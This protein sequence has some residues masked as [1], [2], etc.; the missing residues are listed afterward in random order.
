MILLLH[1]L[2]LFITT[3][4]YY[5]GRVAPYHR[6]CGHRCRPC[7]PPLLSPFLLPSSL[8]LSLLSPPSSLFSSLSSSP[9]SK[10]SS[11]L[12]SN[13]SELARPERSKTLIKA[14]SP[15]ESPMESSELIDGDREGGVG[16]L[17]PS[18]S[19]NSS[20]EYYKSLNDLRGGIDSRFCLLWPTKALSEWGFLFNKRR[21]RFQGSE[22][23]A[24]D[25]GNTGDSLIY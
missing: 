8:S 23:R 17:L 14:C 25:K 5:F 4:L 24:S 21:R 16:E 9:Y 19:E 12:S 13:S 10:S 18:E 1:L 20:S 3:T 15:R 7:P 6:C 11:S 22:N 2:L